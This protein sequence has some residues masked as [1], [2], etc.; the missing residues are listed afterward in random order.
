MASLIT[1]TQRAK[2]PPNEA[3]ILVPA[4]LIAANVLTL[5]LLSAEVIT[6]VDSDFFGVPA[7]LVGN[8]MS[9]SLSILWAT[10]AALLVVV[11]IITSSKVIR[12]A[13]LGL[14]AIPIIKLFVSDV[15]QLEQGYRVAAFLGL[16]GILVAGGF[17]YQRYSRIIRGFLLE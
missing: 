15:F 11:G 6:S 1:W 4:L 10:Y 17:L 9:L 16:G 13:G 5:W 8:V 14:F 12:L 7:R 3:R 2:L